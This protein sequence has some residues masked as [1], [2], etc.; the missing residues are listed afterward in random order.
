LRRR[1]PGTKSTHLP[2][3][4]LAEFHEPFPILGFV[5]RDQPV[6][7]L[8]AESSSEHRALGR[9][10]PGGIGGVSHELRIVSGEVP[11]GLLQGPEVPLCG[12]RTIR[13]IER[14]LKGADEFRHVVEGDLVITKVYADLVKRCPL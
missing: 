2:V 8:M 12:G 11:V 3:D 9:V 13:I 4:L 6:Q 5:G 7:E 14:V 1:G 10:V